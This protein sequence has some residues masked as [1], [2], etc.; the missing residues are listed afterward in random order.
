MLSWYHRIRS[1]F[2]I[3]F[4][5]YLPPVPSLSKDSIMGQEWDSGCLPP[6]LYSKL[7]SMNALL[8]QH[9]RHP[10]MFQSQ[11]HKDIVE[12]AGNDM[13][14]AFRNILQPFVPGLSDDHVLE[15][16][17]VEQER[18]TSWFTLVQRVITFCEQAAVH[19]RYHSRYQRLLLVL[20]NLHPTW[21]AE[22]RHS[23]LADI[24]APRYDKENNKHQL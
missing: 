1:F 13:Y 6:L 11:Q 8:L 20:N 24:I 2:G 10:D 22:L 18:T 4:G 14:V 9:L 17:I 7:G 5:V 19:G 3:Q 21:R 15:K 12:I 16:P 23:C